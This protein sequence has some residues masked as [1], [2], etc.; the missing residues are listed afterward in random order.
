[1]AHAAHAERSSLRRD[2]TILRA[3]VLNADGRPLGT[4][5]LSLISAQDA[6]SAVWRDR[7]SVVETWEDAFFRSPSTTI[8]VP[9]TLM[10]RQYAPISGDP[11]F[12]RR[13]ILLRD[14]FR[15]QYCGEE[16]ASH[17]LTF[18]HVVPRA[19]GGRT[20]WTNIVSACLK[21]NAIK[22]DRPANH[23]GRKGVTGSLRPLKP[24]RRPTNAELLTAGLAFLPNDVREDWGSWLHWHVP[25]RA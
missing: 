12:C 20:E 19:Q 11:K 3:L 22:A 9:K 17:E 21:C 10:L 6:I 14:R 23:S 5:P 4:W 13:S 1:M 18:D 16:F 2:P 15:C 24:P 8:A 25:L 7:A